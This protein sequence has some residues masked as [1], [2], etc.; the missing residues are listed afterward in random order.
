MLVPASWV[1]VGG[2]IE[3]HVNKTLKFRTESW[4]FF[5]LYLLIYKKLIEGNKIQLLLEL[6]SL[7]LFKPLKEWLSVKYFDNQGVSFIDS[8]IYP[9]IHLLIQ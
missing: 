1:G 3:L 7:I 9:C 2:N 4:D 6:G 8:P 5:W